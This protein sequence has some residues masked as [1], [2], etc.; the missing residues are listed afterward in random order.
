MVNYNRLAGKLKEDLTVFLQKISKGM[1]C[2]TKKFILKMIYEIL[3]SNT[4]HLN[5]IARSLEEKNS[6]KKTINRLS[7]NLSS[8][9]GKENIMKNYIRLVKKEINE[10]S[11]VI[12]IDN[13]GITKPYSKKME[14]L[15]DVRDGSTGEIKKGIWPLKL[16]FYQREIKCSCL[17]Y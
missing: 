7:K 6:L 1:K 8:F 3:E 15:S 16:L 12:V 5:G 4:V 13:S 2:P 11:S 9:D 17:S 10:K 14:A